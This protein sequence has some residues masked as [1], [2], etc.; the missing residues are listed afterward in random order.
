MPGAWERQRPSVLTAILT[1]ELVSTRWAKGLREIAMPPLSGVIFKSGQPFDTAR[2]SA[3]DDVL[4]LGFEWLFFLDDDVIPPPDVIARLM[5][6]RLDIVS[7][8]Y[9]RRHLPVK[10]VAMRLTEQGPAWIDNWSPPN[11]MI[12]VDYVGAGCLLI[13]R[14][15][16]EA[17]KRPWFD[18]E[19]GRREATPT[20]NALSEDFAFCAKAAEA[21]FPIHLDTSI[22]CEH[23]GLGMAAPDGSF[24]PAGV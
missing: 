24:V 15:V 2:N 19:I 22:Q 4:A 11:S 13:H 6:H 8:L 9:Y 12:R 21:G 20:R 7:G 5:N 3:V 18:W 17:L 23:V 16:F 1:R 14:R 10:P